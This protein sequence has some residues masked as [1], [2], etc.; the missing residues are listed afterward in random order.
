M[1][2][3]CPNPPT[4]LEMPSPSTD[5]ETASDAPPHLWSQMAPTNR[6]QLSQMLAELI[7][8]IQ[9]PSQE[10]EAVHEKAA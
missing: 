4:E 8:R 2:N 10:K 5:A 7:R 1:L 3:L 6:Q 9:R